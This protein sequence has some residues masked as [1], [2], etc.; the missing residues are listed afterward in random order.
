MSKLTHISALPLVW[1]KLTH[2]GAIQQGDS[3]TAWMDGSASEA[4]RGRRAGRFVPVV[5]CRL[6]PPA[7]EKVFSTRW[8]REM[9]GAPGRTGWAVI[10]ALTDW[11]E[12]THKTSKKYLGDL[13]FEGTM[14]PVFIVSINT[15]LMFH[16]MLQMGLSTR[17][18]WMFFWAGLWLIGLIM[19]YDYIYSCIAQLNSRLK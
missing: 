4:R 13:F 14:I 19:R 9:K 10:G 6:Q 7:S 2:C 18:L 15:V 16:K 5:R 8:E 17:V 3:K 11:R 12:N 1:V